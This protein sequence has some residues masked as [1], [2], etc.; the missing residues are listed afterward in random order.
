MEEVTRR[1]ERLADGVLTAVYRYLCGFGSGLLSDPLLHR[2]V[3]GF[4]V[5]LFWKLMMCLKSFGSQIVYA[6]FNRIIIATNRDTL[7]A[8]HEYVDFILSA[9]AKKDTFAYL[10]VRPNSEMFLLLHKC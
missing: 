10:Q 8:A 9:V 4:M 6:D 2:V 5:K 3:Y 1:G 7:D